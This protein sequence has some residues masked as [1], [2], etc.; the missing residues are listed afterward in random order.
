MDDAAYFMGTFNLR[1]MSHHGFGFYHGLQ[2]NTMYTFLIE[3][4]Q[5]E[6]FMGIEKKIREVLWPIAL[7][8]FFLRM[9]LMFVLASHNLNPFARIIFIHL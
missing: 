9:L 5:R 1:V 4:M 7:V 3:Y 8:L 6:M 2:R